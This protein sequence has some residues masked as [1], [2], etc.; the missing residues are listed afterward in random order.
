MAKVTVLQQFDSITDLRSR[1]NVQLPKP[2]DEWRLIKEPYY[3]EILA[4][5]AMR[6]LAVCTNGIHVGIQSSHRFYIGHL[7]WFIPDELPKEERPRSTHPATVSIDLF[8]CF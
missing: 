1:L 8:R 2:H 3:G 6:G 7:N 5:P 4:C